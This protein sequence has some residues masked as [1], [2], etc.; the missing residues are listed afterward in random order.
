MNSVQAQ[1]GWIQHDYGHLSVFKQ[2]WLNHAFHQYT[3]CFTKGASVHWWNHLHYQ[4]HAKPNVVCRR[5]FVPWGHEQQVDTG[6][7]HDREKQVNFFP[8]MKTQ[9][10][11]TIWK[12]E[13]KHREFYFRK[14][15]TVNS[16]CLVGFEPGS[17]ELR[18]Q[19]STDWA[20]VPPWWVDRVY[21]WKSKGYSVV[22][23][24]GRK[25]GWRVRVIVCWVDEV[26]SVVGWRGR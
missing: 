18:V 20:T 12:I 23:W 13:G 14:I 7:P 1:A 19:C 6:Y 8:A 16:E 5:S 17:S 22:D 24:Q 3:M 15:A 11:L 21:S 4:H 25:C 26:D 9:G 2:S 10:I